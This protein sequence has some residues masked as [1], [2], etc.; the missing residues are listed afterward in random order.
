MRNMKRVP[1]YRADLKTL[2]EQRDDLMKQMKG[3]VDAS[4]AEER[5]MSDEEQ[6]SFS[7][8]EKKIKDIDTTIAA[9]ERARDLGLKVTSNKKHEAEERAEAEEK[10]F[11]QFLRGK[12][13]E[14]RAGEIQLTQ[15]NNGSIVPTSI[16]NRIITAVRDMVPY[17]QFSDVVNTNG[18]L[19]VPVY[20]EDATNFIN[21]DYVDEG[22]EL[23]DNIG[24]F[25]TID[26]TGYV[27]GALALVSKKL[28]N[29]NDFDL[30]TFVVNQVAESM[31]EKLEKEFTV[32]T[33]SKITGI[34]STTNVITSTSATAITYDELVKTKHKLKQRF[35]NNAKWIM[36]ADTYTALCLLKDSNNQPYFKDD[37]YKILNRD[38]L[39]SDS[40]PG[41]AAGNKAI[42]FAD[43]SGYTIK[44]TQAVEI[45][46]LIEKF[47]TK[48]MIGVMAFGEFDAKITDTKK[49][50]AL[51]QKAS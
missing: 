47:A 17:L 32:G 49:I 3:I 9:E 23:V 37:E 26:L 25:T 41:I 35:Q 30:V 14:M 12:L 20:G 4:K 29:N 21:A 43:L 28:I 19:S 33:T 7:D 16:A 18:K 44:A 8:L 50:A 34:T 46:L 45:Q 11:D 51:Q 15:G 1:E 2:N 42:V 22:T 31:A 38:V 39:I 10:A 24:K 36:N 48:N 27:I 40:M 6:T 5:A 13:T